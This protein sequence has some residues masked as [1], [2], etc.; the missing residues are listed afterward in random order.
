MTQRTYTVEEANAAVPGLR[1]QLG[2]IRESR[3]TLIAASHRITDALAADGGGVAGSDWFEASRR[4]RTEVEDLAENG[5][6]LRDPEGGLVDFP[7]E[8]EG[9]IVFLCWRADEDSV[10]WWHEQDSGFIGRR[11]L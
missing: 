5:I 10:G 1:A 8:R 3:Q 7:A 11:A 4:L 6:L 2:R 9:R